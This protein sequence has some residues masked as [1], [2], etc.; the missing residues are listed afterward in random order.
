MLT[1]DS[2]KT[3]GI[4]VEKPVIVQILIIILALA[5]ILPLTL[6]IQSPTTITAN[7][8]EIGGRPNAFKA[9]TFELQRGQMVKGS[10]TYKNFLN[11]TWF[12]ILDASYN[13]LEAR[14]LSSFDSEQ[15]HVTFKFSA[16]STGIYYIGVGNSRDCT[17]NIDYSYTIGSPPVLGF[18]PLLLIT[19][20]IGVSAVLTGINIFVNWIRPKRKSSSL[21]A[22]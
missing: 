14:Y 13:Q 2:I 19:L 5:V 1:K 12:M 20:A 11:D 3:A 16:P 10:L 17:E 6:S 15:N 9:I 22:Q 21:P 18:D 4:R 7:N 8:Q